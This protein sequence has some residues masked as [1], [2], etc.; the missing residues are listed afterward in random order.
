[1][2]ETNPMKFHEALKKLIEQYASADLE[3]IV[4]ALDDEHDRLE[5]ELLRQIKSGALT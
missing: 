3:E 5:D 4:D 2:N 1:M